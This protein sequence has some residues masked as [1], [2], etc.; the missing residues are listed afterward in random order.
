M[1]ETCAR[2]HA[3]SIRKSPDFPQEA[4]LRL[5]LFRETD[6]RSG[7]LIPNTAATERLRGR[8][9]G[10]VTLASIRRL[11]LEPRLRFFCALLGPFGFYPAIQPRALAEIR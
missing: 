5:P 3:S 11:P 8:L 1:L 4:Q 10:A 9:Q 2:P 6:A 7:L